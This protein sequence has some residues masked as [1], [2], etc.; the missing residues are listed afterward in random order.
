MDLHQVCKRA[1]GSNRFPNNIQFQF[2]FDVYALKLWFKM[3]WGSTW[4]KKGDDYAFFAGFNI[5]PD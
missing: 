2:D 5:G 1:M 3:R 4:L